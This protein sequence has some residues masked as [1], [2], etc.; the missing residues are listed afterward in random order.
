[1]AWNPACDP[2]ARPPMH[3]V[4]FS[5]EGATCS[6]NKAKVA[7]PL[8]PRRSYQYLGDSRGSW[9]PLRQLPG[10]GGTQ[11][12]L[13]R[14]PGAGKGLRPPCLPLFAPPASSLRHEADCAPPLPACPEGARDPHGTAL[15]P[16]LVVPGPPGGAL[17]PPASRSPEPPAEDAPAHPLPPGRPA[18]VLWRERPRGAQAGGA[19]VP[20]VGTGRS[21]GAHAAHLAR[22]QGRHPWAPSSLP[23]WHPARSLEGSFQETRLPERARPSQPAEEPRRQIPGKRGP[24]APREPRK[25]S[26]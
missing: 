13:T 9:L 1:M 22:L 7:A 23:L 16:Q 2:T 24:T 8:P 26:L 10:A 20:G 3:C 18:G 4:V 17:P 5:V 19:E 12:A 14:S 11:S 21:K 6:P 25:D 15:L